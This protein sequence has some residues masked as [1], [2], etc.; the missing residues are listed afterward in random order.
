MEIGLVDFGP[1][2]LV[3]K[4]HARPIPHRQMIIFSKLWISQD[5]GRSNPNL[6]LASVISLEV[7]FDRGFARS[8]SAKKSHLHKHIVWL[9]QV[10]LVTEGVFL[11]AKWFQWSVVTLTLD[12]VLQAMLRVMR[13]V[14]EICDNVIC[15]RIGCE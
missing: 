12:F 15:Q 11:C 5:Q 6:Y 1:G 4:H 9:L 10:T 8:P 14:K 7:I 3:V 13:L 2:F